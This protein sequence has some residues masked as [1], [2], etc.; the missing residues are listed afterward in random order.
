MP[1]Y[2]YECKTCGIF[3]AEH[4]MNERLEACKCGQPVKRL[5]AAPA[6]I[7]LKGGGYYSD[8]RKND[9]ATREIKEKKLAHLTSV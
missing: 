7:V 3:E 2:D 6:G 1:N 4:P 9:K 5:I 8:L